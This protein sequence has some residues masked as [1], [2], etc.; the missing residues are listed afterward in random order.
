MKLTLTHTFLLVPDQDKALAFYRDVLGLEVRTD[1]PLGP[2]RWLSVGPAA[3]PE[4]EIVLETPEMNP[5]IDAAAV[6]DLMAKG[7]MSRTIIFA[8]D[9]C[10]ATFDQLKAAGVEVTQ[11]PIDQ[12][13]GVRD[14]GVR[15]PFGNHLR[16]SE[17]RAG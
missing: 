6:R 13:Y 11:E 14:F 16:F 2:I 5:T 12:P 9:D 3:Q 17:M 8:T 15:D 4:L 1:A 10:D 7:T